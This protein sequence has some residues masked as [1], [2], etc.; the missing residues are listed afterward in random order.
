MHYCDNDIT[1]R[2]ASKK[3]AKRKGLDKAS[4]HVSFEDRVKI[5]V[6]LNPIEGVL[7]GGEKAFAKC[8]LPTL[9]PC[10]RLVHF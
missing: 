10:R 9:I 7:N 8:L 3:N 5:R 6:E 1:L 4:S 2:C